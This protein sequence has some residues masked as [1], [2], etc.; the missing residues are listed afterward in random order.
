MAMEQCMG[1]WDG[2]NWVHISCPLVDT[3]GIPHSPHQ[4]DP[5]EYDPADD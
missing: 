1:T 3:I 5:D 4:F 2:D